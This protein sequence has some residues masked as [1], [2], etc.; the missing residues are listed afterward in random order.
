MLNQVI[1]F[2]LDIIQLSKEVVG[3]NFRVKERVVKGSK[4]GGDTLRQKKKEKRVWRQT[5][6]GDYRE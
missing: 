3:K 2:R 5:R 4:V 6:Y 1:S